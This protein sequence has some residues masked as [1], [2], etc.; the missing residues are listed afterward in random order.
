MDLNQAIE[1]HAEWKIRFRTAITKHESMDVGTISKDNCCEL[2][3]WLHGIGKAKFSNLPSFMLCISNHAKFHVEAG[4]IAQTIN[5]KKY[6]EAE[7]MLS[8]GTSYSL[9]SSGVGVAIIQ[10]KKD[11]QI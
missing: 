5:A 8:T 7:A 9:A 11:T 4:K 1:K 2:G 3:K 6:T 10:L